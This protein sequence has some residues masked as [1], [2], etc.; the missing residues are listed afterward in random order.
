MSSSRSASASLARSSRNLSRHVASALLAGAADLS[1][2]AALLLLATP[3]ASALSLVASAVGDAPVDDG[4]A[5]EFALDGG[6]VLTSSFVKTFLGFGAS[7]FCWRAL[8]AASATGS[9]PCCCA[10][11]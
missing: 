8:R 10:A 11:S 7:F 3:P 9:T 4:V 2:A 6:I 1:P 5:L